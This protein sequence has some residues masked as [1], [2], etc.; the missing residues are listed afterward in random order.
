MKIVRCAV[1]ASLAGAS[2]GLSACHPNSA[3]SGSS[4]ASSAPPVA[5]VNG[6]TIS[7]SMFEFV[8]KND[9]AQ[10]QK[11]PA[12]LTPQERE[13]ALD[14]LIDAEL[15]TQQADKDGTLKS[16]DATNQLELARLSASQQIFSE[17]F[18]KDNKPTDQ[19]L[20]AE[21]DKQVALLPHTE[22]HARHIL[23]DSQE[24]AQAIIAK[25]AKG[26]K[27]DELAKTESSDPSSKNGGDLGWFSPDRM[28][29]EFSDA[30]TA[31]K[32]GDYTTVPV[33]TQYGWHVIKLEETRPVTPPPFDNPQIKQQLEQM[34]LR[35]KFKAYVDGLKKTAQIDKK[36]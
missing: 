35:T 1:I 14:G 11:T 33:H 3:A 18:V 8:L 19:E 17:K 29:K 31:L 30:V 16:A 4:A 13:A 32:P 28:V 25:L 7:R 6:A 27:F 10:H 34:V 23:V 5:T 2:L 12:D 21:Y 20:K 9:A 36:L 22:Y 15:V 24:K 26:A